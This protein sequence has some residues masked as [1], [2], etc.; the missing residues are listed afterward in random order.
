MAALEAEEYERLES[1][2]ASI[3]A[4]ELKETPTRYQFNAVLVSA[5]QGQITLWRMSRVFPAPSGGK[6]VDISLALRHGPTL[7]LAWRLRHCWRA[8]GVT[9]GTLEV[10]L[11]QALI[12]VRASTRDIR[13]ELFSEVSPHLQRGIDPKARAALEAEGSG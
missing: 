10:L 5:L 2:R 1:L 12:A 6:R 9:D 7:E 11:Q 8:L 3:N 4:L 13:A